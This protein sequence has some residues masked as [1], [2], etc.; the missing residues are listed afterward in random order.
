MRGL[1]PAYMGERR[2]NLVQLSEAAFKHFHE[3]SRKGAK[4]MS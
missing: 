1:G 4:T 3:G 2:I